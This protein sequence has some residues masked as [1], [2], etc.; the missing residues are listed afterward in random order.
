MS[1]PIRI[2]RRRTP[3]WRAPVGAVAVSRGT[4]WGNPFK[5]NGDYPNPAEAVDFF[6]RWLM[7]ADF[8]WIP[9]ATDAARDEI[10][11]RLP[12]L[13][14]CDLMCWCGKGPCHADVLIELANKEPE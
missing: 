9:G 11:S 10:L 6:R 12:E 3:G 8:S 5:A 14:G 4:I 13:R 7:G 2:T 1:E